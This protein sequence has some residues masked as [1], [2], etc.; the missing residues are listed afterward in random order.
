MA[1]LEADV[2]FEIFSANALATGGARDL[3]FSALIAAFPLLDAGGPGAVI[4]PI[5]LALA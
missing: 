3:L 4:L 1:V 2:G 5:V